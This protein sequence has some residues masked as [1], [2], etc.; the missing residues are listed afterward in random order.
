MKV[1]MMMVIVGCSHGLVVPSTNEF[2]A[3]SSFAACFSK[4]LSS[5]STFLLCSNST[6][7]TRSNHPLFTNRIVVYL[8]LIHYHPDVHAQH[9]D[10]QHHRHNSISTEMSITDGEFVLHDLN[11]PLAEDWKWEIGTQQVYHRDLFGSVWSVLDPLWLR[12][13]NT[14]FTATTNR[15]CQM[16]RSLFWSNDAVLPTKHANSFPF[17]DGSDVDVSGGR[18][19][20]GRS[21][22]R[23]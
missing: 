1:A 2:T 14:T 19:T 5:C 7:W 8:Y 15:S 11:T 10:D 9:W 12:D 16:S 4:A 20:L 18:S 22:V 13:Q 6:T 17:S 21:N 23:Q 3:V